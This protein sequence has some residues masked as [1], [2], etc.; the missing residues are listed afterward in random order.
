MK[1]QDTV[2]KEAVMTL[3]IAKAGEYL[4]S[5]AINDHIK[6]DALTEVAADVAK[7]EPASA[8]NAMDVKPPLETLVLLRVE[9]AELNG[10]RKRFVGTG[11][12][13]R[14]PDGSDVWRRVDKEQREI[15][16]K[17]ITGWQLLPR[18]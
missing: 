9:Y 12:Y 8:W 5:A 11:T 3:I 13:S 15:S 18:P 6:A 10:E 4:E 16:P 17:I 1:Y 7:M 2:S 14:R